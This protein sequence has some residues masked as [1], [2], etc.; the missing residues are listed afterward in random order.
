MTQEA[1]EIAILAIKKVLN[2]EGITEEEIED[3]MGSP[4]LKGKENKYF[5]G[6]VHWAYH[7]V[8]DQNIRLKDPELDQVLRENLTEELQKLQ[9]VRKSSSNYR[10]KELP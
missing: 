9:E 2:D 7:F 8:I 4:A 5:A 6:V 10:N 3:I 1:L